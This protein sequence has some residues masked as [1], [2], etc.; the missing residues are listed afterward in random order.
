MKM[1][2]I[3]ENAKSV[4]D[5]SQRD[6]ETM[7]RLDEILWEEISGMESGKMLKEVNPVGG[8]EKAKAVQDIVDKLDSRLDNVMYVGDSITDVPPFQ[9]VRENGGLTISFNGNEYAIR[10]AEIAV[11][12]GN[13]IVNSVLADGFSR[14]GKDHVMK[15]VE[16]WSPSGLKK[17]CATPMLLERMFKLYP[18]ILPQVEIITADNRERL[19]KESS[20]F[21][22]SVRGEA[23]GKLG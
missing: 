14:F 6:Q 9:L 8:Y 4:R 12:S 21:R 10:E 15:L 2:E 3:P 1:I 11:L 23:I 19:K 13:T 18:R 20:A 7:Q 16:E 17:Y 5:F 22:K